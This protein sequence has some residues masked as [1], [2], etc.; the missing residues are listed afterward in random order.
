LRPYCS[1]LACDASVC[2]RI[3]LALYLAFYAS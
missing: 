2:C 3:A 1:K